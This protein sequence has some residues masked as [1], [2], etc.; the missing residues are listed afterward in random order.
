MTGRGTNGKFA[1]GD[2]PD[3]DQRAQRSHKDQGHSSQLEWVTGSSAVER[4]I[5][6]LDNSSVEPC[7]SKT[8][9]A[10]ESKAE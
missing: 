6:V 1:K 4:D 9:N 3:P 5:G 2:D 10:S 8:E 7:Q